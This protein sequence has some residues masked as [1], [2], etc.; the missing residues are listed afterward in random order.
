ME[1]KKHFVLVHG[2]CFGAWVWYK[3]ASLLK[4][5]GHKVTSIDMKSSRININPIVAEEVKSITDYSQPLFD[6]MA[7]LPLEERVILVGHSLGGISISLAME[8]FHQKISVAVFL[9]AVMPG[10]HLT[11]ELIN[12]VVSICPS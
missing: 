12:Q 8:I 2:T 9:T 6:L 4:S 5:N 1:V 10:P 3:L 7:S 11:M